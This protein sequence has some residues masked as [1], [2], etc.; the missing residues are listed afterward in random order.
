MWGRDARELFFIDADRRLAGVRVL[1]GAAFVASRPERVSEVVFYTDLLS[2][3]HDISPDGKRFLVLQTVP[4]T[5]QP[6]ILIVE[7]WTREL[8]GLSGR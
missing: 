5:R 8:T 7:N 2:R 3:G 1:P 4:D 6:N